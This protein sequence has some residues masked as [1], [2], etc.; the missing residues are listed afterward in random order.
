M[1]VIGELKKLC[2][3]F[4]YTKSYAPKD[5]LLIEMLGVHQQA[6]KS[7]YTK[8]YLT[9]LFTIS[10]AL[11]HAQT[12]NYY[13]TTRVSDSRDYFVRWLFLRCS[14]DDDDEF[15]AL[16]TDKSS[17]PIF[18]R[19]TISASILQKRVNT[20]S[21]RKSSKKE[22]SSTKKGGGGGTKTKS[23]PIVINYK[24]I[25]EIEE[26]EETFRAL[27][28][29]NAELVGDSYLSEEALALHE[30]PYISPCIPE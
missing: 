26:F 29:W 2:S 8:G 22:N 6:V 30:K 25:E 27:R 11:L 17:L 18:H 5:Q 28:K 24:D 20:Q 21:T 19:Q 23:R 15:T 4:K 10:I 13:V 12:Q 7:Q 9:D 3:V 14:L 1:R 16:V